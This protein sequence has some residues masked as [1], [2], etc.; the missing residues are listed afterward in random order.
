MAAAERRR[1]VRLI[2]L[3]RFALAITVF[4]LLGHTVLGFEQS[5]AQPLVALATAYGMDLLLEWIEARAHRRRPRFAGGPSALFHFLLPAHITALAVT[6]LLYANDRLW[7]MVFATAVGIGSKAI[8]R[9][10]VNGSR[11]HFMNPSNTGI[12]AT[13]LLFPWV[14]IAPPYMFT[15]ELTGWMDWA[16]PGL[17][18]VSGSVL[19]ASLTRKVP[20]ILAWVGGFFLQASLRSA[21]FGT[22]LVACLLP[23]TGVAFVLFTFYMVTDPGTTPFRPRSQVAFGLVLA[24]AY[25]LLM[26]S[27]V[28]FGLFFALTAVCALRGALLASRAWLLARGRVPVPETAGMVPGP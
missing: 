10:A 28:V 5:W 6:M 12:T 27:H 18:V 3:R 20:L 1:D 23:M 25:G 15:E 26:A 2:A 14:G 17:I 21:L 9:V 16:L 13:L 7:P 11:R 22:P 8:L 19:N 24:A 4:N